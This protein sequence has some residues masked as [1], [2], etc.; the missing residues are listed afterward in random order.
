MNQLV[1][2][3]SCQ[4]KAAQVCKALME[5]YETCHSSV[6]GTGRYQD[7]QHCAREL[8]A[9]LGCVTAKPKHAP[10]AE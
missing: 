6:M 3:L 5:R 7:R 9:V 4:T 2:M 10:G 8:S 1:K